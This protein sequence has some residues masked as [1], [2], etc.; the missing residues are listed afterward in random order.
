MVSVMTWRINTRLKIHPPELLRV[1]ADYMQP[2]FLLTFRTI[3]K[4]CNRDYPSH[5]G[6]VDNNFYDPAKDLVYR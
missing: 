1:R 2:V 6:I 5:N 4:Y 3:M